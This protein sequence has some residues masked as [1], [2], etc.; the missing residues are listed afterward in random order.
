MQKTSS[1]LNTIY[2]SFFN[3]TPNPGIVINLEGMITLVNDAALNLLEYDRKEVLEKSIYS[4]LTNS[5]EL[6]AKTYQAIKSLL[7]GTRQCYDVSIKK[8]TGSL[9]KLK[10]LTVPYIMERKL[11]GIIIYLNPIFKEN[12][13]F[14]QFNDIEA[15]KELETVNKCLWSIN[16]ETD[17]IFHITSECEKI[18]GY[19]QNDFLMYPSLWLSVIHPDDFKRVEH[20]QSKLLKGETINHEYRIID[21][22]QNLKWISE[23]SVPTLNE[24][25]KLIKLEGVIIDISIRKR[26]EEKLLYLAYY[27]SLTG[28]PNRVLFE[29]RLEKALEKAIQT[30]REVFL[31]YLDLDRFKFINDTLGHRAGDELLII[32]AN[33]LKQLLGNH[34]V[35]RL[36]GD[37][38]AILIEEGN[39]EDIY[40]IAKEIQKM[41]NQ[42]YVLSNQEYFLT[43][44]IG[45]SIFPDHAD[46]S[47]EL[48]KL[49]DQAMYLAKQ[50]GKGNFQL[51]HMG[52]TTDLS[53]KVYIEQSLHK[54]IEKNE[55]NLHYQPIVNAE[56]Q[57][58]LGFE[59]LIRWNHSKLGPISPLE[60]IEVAE[61]SGLIIPIGEWVLRRAC[62]DSRTWREKG[63]P[64]TYVSVNVSTR[65]FIQTNFIEVLEN[66][67]TETDMD[68]KLLKIEITE[69]TSMMNVEQIIGKM[70]RLK[71]LGIDIFLDDFGTGY[72]SLSY[73]KKFP[74]NTLKIDK[75]FISDINNNIN[76]ESIIKAIIAMVERLKINVIAEGVE[77][78]EQI[79]FLTELGCNNMQGYH[80]NK[81]L[82][83]ERL[84]EFYEKT[85]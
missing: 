23:Y 47:I 45:I 28:L 85:L 40:Y 58:V 44:S 36:S 55:L 33:R 61:E 52:I 38:F 77:T 53:R 68:P 56:N 13:Y 63:L 51:Y 73:L 10:A 18:Y 24:E 3:N 26:T 4:L 37:E 20:K 78:N 49:A 65:Q 1:V 15:N 71:D 66:I 50:K 11:L 59:A 64:T 43:S 79:S 67:L 46:N 8:R 42:P 22:N 6:S 84:C 29:E 12:G 72:S 25:G 39:L 7:T 81:P 75:T 21:A 54:A 57:C 70:N 80:F 30:S 69:S 9:M 60:C 62:L 14:G 19:N 83:L 48:L 31:L 82:P 16:T 32:T 5:E 41:I 74:I 2:A 17:N 34:L 27:D 76:Q 35:S